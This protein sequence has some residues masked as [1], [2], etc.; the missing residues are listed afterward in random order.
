MIHETYFLVLKTITHVFKLPGGTYLDETNATSV[1]LCKPC[2]ET[3]Y[4]PQGSTTDGIICPAGFYCVGDQASG[5]QNACPIG[6]YGPDQ[7][8]KSMYNLT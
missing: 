4:C 7:G 3:K 8:Y 6:T 1:T 2:P 5:F